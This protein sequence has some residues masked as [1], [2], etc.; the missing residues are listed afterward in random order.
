LIFKII[1]NRD[2]LKDY[3]PTGSVITLFAVILTVIAFMFMG[4]YASVLL[5]STTLI[6]WLSAS[7]YSIKFAV[8]TVNGG[9]ERERHIKDNVYVGRGTSN[10]TKGIR[11]KKERNPKSTMSMVWKDYDY[12][13]PLCFGDG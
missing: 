1:K 5:S 2:I 13:R 9:L 10:A 11:Y 3:S 6:L 12:A 8:W 4:N 7:I